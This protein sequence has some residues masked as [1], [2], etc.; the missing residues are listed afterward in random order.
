MGIREVGRKG[1]PIL[2]LHG[3]GDRTLN[4]RCSQNLYDTYG[5]G[6]KDGDRKLKLFEGDDHA[7]TKNSLKAEELLCDFIMRCAGVDIAGEEK[8]EVVQKPLIQG[9]DRIE[10]MKQGG[11]LRGN[12]SI[13]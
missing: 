12:E 2:L 6:M 11:D 5:H 1:I 8:K 13:D 7:L 10:K 9:K 4:P 3:T